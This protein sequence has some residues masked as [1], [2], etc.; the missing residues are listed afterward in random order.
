MSHTSTWL[1]VFKKLI[2]GQLCF[3]TVFSEQQV[4]CT[5][6]HFSLLL[7]YYP[8]IVSVAIP[9]QPLLVSEHPLLCIYL[10]MCVYLHMYICTHH[11]KHLPLFS[12]LPTI[13]T[14]SP[15]LSL[16]S[17]WTKVMGI[18]SLTSLSC[19]PTLSSWAQNKSPPQAQFHS[20]AVVS[21]APRTAFRVINGKWILS[22][23]TNSTRRARKL[24]SLV[25]GKDKINKGFPT[26]NLTSLRNWELKTENL[27]SRMDNILA[28]NFS[29]LMDLS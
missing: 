28:C 15:P 4:S 23:Q 6:S 7:V 27:V 10:H 12:I 18:S 22:Q 29:A 13:K 11:G 2:C 9:P 1:I 14:K 17:T 3:N 24:E 21:T 5:F 25:K 20:P 16:H 8:I 26:G 19:N